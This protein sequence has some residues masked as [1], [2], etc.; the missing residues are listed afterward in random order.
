MAQRT[1]LVISSTELAA[2]LERLAGHLRKQEDDFYQMAYDSTL[3]VGAE[4]SLALVFT[5]DPKTHTAKT[6]KITNTKTVV[7]DWNKEVRSK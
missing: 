2:I 5:F 7:K 6:V 4:H 1:P 3:K